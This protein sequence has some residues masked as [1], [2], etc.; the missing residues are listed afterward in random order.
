MVATIDELVAV[1][2]QL[3]ARRSRVIVGI[4]GEPGSGK[5]TVAEAISDQVD[6]RSVIVPMDGFHLSNRE[7]KRLGRS[8]RKGA[9]DTFDV[10]GYVNLLRRLRDVDDDVVY[11][12]EYV[13]D[14]EEPIGGAIAVSSDIPVV[15]TEGNYLLH[16]E[17]GW[18]AVAPLLDGVWYLDSEPQRRVQR[19]IRRH[20]R[21]GKT[22]DDAI[23]WATGSD[24][25]NASVVRRTR[26][27][28]NLW[29][30]GDALLQ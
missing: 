4:V 25:R 18:D 23:A 12:P 1:V 22:S 2:S 14:L 26:P 10:A 13:R 11:A 16:S 17:H 3:L 19:L 20:E 29:I 7:L 21:F 15:F 30:D 27:A 6:C 28:A 9:P 5:S 8:E 24:E